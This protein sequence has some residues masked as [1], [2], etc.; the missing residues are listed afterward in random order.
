MKVRYRFGLQLTRAVNVLQKE[1]SDVIDIKNPE[2]TSAAERR[3]ARLEAEAS[4]FSTDHY[5]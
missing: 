5:L 1:L 4:A 3:Q 2:G